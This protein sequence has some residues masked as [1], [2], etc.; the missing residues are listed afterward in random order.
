MLGRWDGSVG[1]GPSGKST[2]RIQSSGPTLWREL[3][4]TSCLL[5]SMCEL[6]V[7]CA[8]PHTVVLITSNS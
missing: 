4:P 3:T 1:E 2:A 7:A 5:T 6:A 8:F